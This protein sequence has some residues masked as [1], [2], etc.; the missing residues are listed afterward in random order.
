M[1]IS[2]SHEVLDNTKH[3]DGL[4]PKMW[5]LLCYILLTCDRKLPFLRAIKQVN[6][7]KMVLKLAE[8]YLGSK[9]D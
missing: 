9:I 1:L 8:Q 3:I 5:S 7:W 2:F 4:R 6:L